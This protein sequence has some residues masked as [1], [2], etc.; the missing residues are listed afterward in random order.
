[1]T[2]L[3]TLVALGLAIALA[4]SPG[5]AASKR[6]HVIAKVVQQTFT[7]NLASPKL[8]DRII[9]YAELF[10]DSEKVGAGAGVCFAVVFGLDPGCKLRRAASGTER[11]T[12]SPRRSC[13]QLG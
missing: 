1:M 13:L 8:G 10:D 2:R 6:I 5:E 4:P 11:P 9:Q 12:V 3:S 7:G